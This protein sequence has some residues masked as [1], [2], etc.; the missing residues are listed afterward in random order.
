MLRREQVI[1]IV[2]SWDIRWKESEGYSLLITDSRLIGA[3][4]PDYPDNFWAYLGPGTEA[5]A[6]SRAS[7]DKK[8]AEIVAREDFELQRDRIVKIMYDE[9]GS[10]IG[11]RL[12]LAVVG[13]RVELNITVASGWNPGIVSTL[14]TLIDSLAAFAPCT[15]YSEKTGQ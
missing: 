4:R 14:K 15:F 12:L 8:A 1:G 5:S 10:L 11:G 2:S 6:E 7:A 13:R 3:S 9:P